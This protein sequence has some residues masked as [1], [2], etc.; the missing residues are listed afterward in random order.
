MDFYIFFPEIGKPKKLMVP[1][2][3]KHQ[4]LHLIG[5]KAPS[6]EMLPIYEFEKIQEDGSVLVYLFAYVNEPST[7]EIET[8]I[9]QLNLDSV[10]KDNEDD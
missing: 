2:N 7:A 3:G 10:V 8:A 4:L 5:S 1:P 9:A 6:Y